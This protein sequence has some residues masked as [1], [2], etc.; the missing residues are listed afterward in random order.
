MSTRELKNI[1]LS[2]TFIR[3]PRYTNS[4]SL[5]H[6]RAFFPFIINLQLRCVDAS[7]IIK[8]KRIGCEA[9]NFEAMWLALKVGEQ[10]KGPLNWLLM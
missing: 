3:L 7:V 4:M 10:N 5:S 1:L 9:V 8:K 6:Y 2:M